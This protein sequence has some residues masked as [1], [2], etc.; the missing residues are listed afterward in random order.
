MLHIRCMNADFRSFIAHLN[1][2]DSLLASLVESIGPLSWPEPRPHFESLCRAIIGQQLSTKAAQTIFSRFEEWIVAKGGFSAT[3][4]LAMEE[5]AYTEIGISQQKKNYLKA[6][7][8]SW[9]SKP[10]I[11]EHFDSMSDHQITTQLTQIK[12]IGPWTAQMFLMFT[13]R[14]PDVFAP[15]D[16]GIKK[17]MHK[18][19]ELPMASSDSVWTDKASAWS[20]YRSWACLYLWKSLDL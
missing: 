3:A 11:F 4:V 5:R 8:E 15:G 14:R 19:Y 17:A 16:L 12:G 7:G 2:S 10:E 18:L 9:S 13:L 1:D 6:L 20:P